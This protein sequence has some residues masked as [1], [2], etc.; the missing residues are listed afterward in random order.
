MVVLLGEQDTNAKDPDLDQSDGSLK[1]GATR[2]ERG[3]NFFGAATTSAR[4]LGVKLGWE[5]SYVPGAGHDS[6]K[7]LKAAADYV[8]GGKK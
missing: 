2:L 1:Q 3:E 8:W 6:A 4:D 7:M 5:M